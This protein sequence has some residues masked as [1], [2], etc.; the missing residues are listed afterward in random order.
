MKM[1]TQHIKT[2]GMYE[3]SALREIYSCKHLFLKN[4]KEKSTFKA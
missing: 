1:E 2:Y 3:N 4:K